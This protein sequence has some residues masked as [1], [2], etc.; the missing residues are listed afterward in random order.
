MNHFSSFACGKIILSGEY[1]VVFGYPGIAVPSKETITI[2]LEKIDNC[3]LKIENSIEWP[4]VPKPWLKYAEK[5]VRLATNNLKEMP[6][7]VLRIKTDLPLGK[8]MGSS[9]ALVIALCRCLLGNDCRKEALEIEN[10]LNPDHSGLDFAVI[11][12]EKPIYFRKG[13]APKP[14]NLPANLLKESRLIDTGTPN[15]TTPELVAWVR[16]RCEL[17]ITPATGAPRPGYG[18]K[19]N[20]RTAIEIIGR[21]ADRIL[22][23][24][25]LE[26]VFHDHHR[27]QVA[28][29]V[30]TPEAQKI[31]AG[32][33]EKGGAA[34]V[35]GAGART[36][37]G[38]MILEI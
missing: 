35:L 2:T 30:V 34:K 32:I 3:K 11:W 9:T 21:C 1:A 27:A 6:R 18:E 20:T 17:P 37:G 26:S 16:S 22:S 8:G 23:G 33:E 19:T 4:D 5:I 12:E 36:G 15:E 24:E 31:I 29:G 38:G 13:V 14:I 7:G 25:S 10:E 28:L